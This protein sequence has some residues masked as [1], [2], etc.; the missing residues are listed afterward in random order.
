MLSDVFTVLA[1]DAEIMAVVACDTEDVFTVK[2][3]SLCP[4]GTVSVGGSVTALVELDSPTTTPPEPAGC[5][6]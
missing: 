1:A 4:E 2:I 3:A 5:A 6:K